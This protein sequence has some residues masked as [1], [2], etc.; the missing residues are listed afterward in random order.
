MTTHVHLVG[1]VALDTIAARV[2]RPMQW[3]H[4]PVPIDR[5]DDAFY[6]PLRD[7][8]L[9]P[10]TEVFLGL[11]H[12]Q[13]GVEGTRRRMAVAS[14]LVERFG[15]AS[16]CGISRGRDRRT[17]KRFLEVYAGAAAAGPAE[18]AGV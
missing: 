15:S 9:H 16:E 1:S 8:R 11:V 5:V 10:E 14:K 18:L 13:D 7:L 3:I 6:A 12:V 17:A 2:Q 4:L